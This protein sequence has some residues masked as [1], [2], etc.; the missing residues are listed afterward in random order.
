MPRQL[1][2]QRGWEWATVNSHKRRVKSARTSD[3]AR[4]FLYTNRQFLYTNRQM[5]FKLVA[6]KQITVGYDLLTLNYD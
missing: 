3:R 2:P 6:E 5:V 4:T 1:S